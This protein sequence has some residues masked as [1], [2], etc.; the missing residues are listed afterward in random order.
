VHQVPARRALEESVDDLDV[1]D[2][3]ELDALL[4]EAP[5]VVA[6]GLIGLLTAPFE[7][8]GVPRAHV[9]ALEVADED[10]DQVGPIVDLVHGQVLEPRSCGVSKVKGKVADGNRVFRRTAQLAC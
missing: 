3:G 7:V 9:S 1:R 10:L 5:H 8:P 4:G 2:A 6:Q